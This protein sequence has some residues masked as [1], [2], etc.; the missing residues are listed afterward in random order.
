VE[1][2]R[3]KLLQSEGM[4][5]AYNHMAELVQKDRPLP[6][7]LERLTGKFFAG[8]GEAI[9]LSEMMDAVRQN[10]H[11]R[12][13][14]IAM[15]FDH[16]LDLQTVMEAS[17]RGIPPDQLELEA[18]DAVLKESH[19]VGQGKVNTVE[20]CTYRGSDGENKVLVFKPELGARR[21]L[22]MLSAGQ[23]GYD[24]R[25]RAMQLN[26]AAY[27]SA[28]AIGCGD[29][30]AKSSI[31]SHNGE[32]GL[33]MEAAPGMTP[34]GMRE[35]GYLC[36]TA[37]GRKLSHIEAV[38][39]MT[40]KGTLRDVRA[41]LMREC[42]KLEWAD[43]LSGQVDRHQ[44]NYLVRINPDTGE[45]KVTGI[46]NDASFGLRRVGLN[47]VDVSG[48]TQDELDVTR[49]TGNPNLVDL[50]VLSADEMATM[51]RTFGFN[52]ASLPTCIDKE[53]LRQLELINVG[54][55]RQAML[56]CMGEAA[57]DAAVSRLE[58]VKAYAATLPVVDDWTSQA[59]SS[60]VW[61]GRDN[62]CLI[63]NGFYNRDFA[64][65]FGY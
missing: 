13:E 49:D 50:A 20:L 2:A 37:D 52:Q 51:Q 9:E 31:G 11:A 21:G 43:L 24:P 27:R 5:E 38:E 45:V 44:K 6:P 56:S 12:A 3:G 1:V 63:R 14:Y 46:D 17:L 47:K 19:N 30:I 29:V 57:A 64:P 23:L 48:F 65:Y 55:Y 32:I 22:N 4:V 33:F 40:E 35:K 28:A 7:A 16:N 41:N 18:G 10:R 34:Y 15:A 61:G 58:A 25:V 59:A 39:Y 62:E 36:E 8:H 53:T 60:L 42:N 54:E 26:V